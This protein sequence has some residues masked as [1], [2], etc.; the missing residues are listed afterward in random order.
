MKHA[1]FSVF[2]LCTRGGIFQ[3]KECF[4]NHDPAWKHWC[5][6]TARVEVQS[7]ETRWD[8]HPGKADGFIFTHFPKPRDRVLRHAH[9]G[10]VL[11]SLGFCSPVHAEPRQIKCSSHRQAGQLCK[12]FVSI[13]SCFCCPIVH[14][15]LLLRQAAWFL[16]TWRILLQLLDATFL[17]SLVDTQSCVS[18]CL[19]FSFW[20]V[21]GWHLSLLTPPNSLCSL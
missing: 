14:T 7:R 15:L 11:N 3:Q 21:S 5:K 12:Q 13:C 2:I 16:S 17:L 8:A 1:S 20:P 4:G 10:A 6:V 19:T 18:L 9:S